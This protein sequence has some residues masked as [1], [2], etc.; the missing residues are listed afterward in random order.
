MKKDIKEAET[1]VERVKS[2][3]MNGLNGGGACTNVL[4]LAGLLL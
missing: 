3:A 1:S 4:T 2:E